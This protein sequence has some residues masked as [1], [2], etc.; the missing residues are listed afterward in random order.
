M[1]LSLGVAALATAVVTAAAQI[2]VASIESD[3]TRIT[4]PYLAFLG[5]F[6]I[7]IYAHN[8]LTRGPRRSQRPERLVTVFAVVI[9]ALALLP[10]WLGD[11]EAGF[12]LQMSAQFVALAL[13]LIGLLPPI[14]KARNAA[15]AARAATAPDE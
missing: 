9:L 10:I 2:L 5:G 13:C 6:V 8:A 1:R 7:T 11:R 15:D 3:T 4:N 12:K 14:V